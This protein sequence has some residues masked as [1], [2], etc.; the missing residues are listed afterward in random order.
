MGHAEPITAG[1]I[2]ATPASDF[3]RDAWAG[4]VRPEKSINPKWLYDQTGS[5]LFEQITTVPEYYLTRTEI[6]I[7]QRHADDLAQLV[8]TGGALVELGSGASVK[9]RTLLDAGRH[10]SAYVPIDISA[11]FLNLTADDL[12]ARYPD[13]SVRPIVGDFLEPVALPDDMASRPKVGF[14]PG[15]TIGNITPA[16]AVD[17]LS[18]ARAWPGIEAFI[19]G[20]DLV[21]APGVLVDAY[22]DAAGVTAQFITNVLVRMNV[23]LDA[24][25]NIADFSY[26][27]RWNVQDARIEMSLISRKAQ[28]VDLA[29]RQIAFTEGEAID[30]SM[31]RKY[32]VD[33]L[34]Q[35]A[36]ASGWA[37]KQMHCDDAKQFT[38]A[39]LTPT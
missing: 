14:F 35:L 24:D 16:D 26:Q 27:A 18:R 4:L 33:S 2:V 38:V 3:L 19:M 8:P 39:V 36:Q 17:L 11:A 32:T 7:L 9:T 15:S 25:F 28:T 21:K 37:I 20:V 6:S 23:E 13:L 12:R 34:T 30:V 10:L 1:D 29:G 31:S 22:D 5:A